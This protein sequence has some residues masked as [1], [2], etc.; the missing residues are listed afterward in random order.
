[1]DPRDRDREKGLSIDRRVAVIGLAT[2]GLAPARKLLAQTPADLDLKS[3]QFTTAEMTRVDIEKQLAKGV[4]P[5]LVGKSS[6]ASISR[7]SILPALIFSAP[8]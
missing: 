8:G 1:M 3:P 4:K 5:K 6:M 2:L 7:G